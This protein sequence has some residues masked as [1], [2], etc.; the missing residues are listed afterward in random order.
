MEN[1]EASTPTSRIS[2]SGR[3]HST[4]RERILREVESGTSTTAA[5]VAATGL[6]ENTVRGHLERLHA[7]GF[8][9][10]TRIAP[11]GRGRP[12]WHWHAILP[13]EA[14]YAELA[15]TL[16]EAMIHPDDDPVTSARAA[17]V[18]WGERIVRDATADATVRATPAH[19]AASASLEPAHDAEPVP[20]TAAPGVRA[21]SA[22]PAASAD[23]EQAHDVESAP[24]SPESAPATEPPATPGH[25][26]PAGVA[27]SSAFASAWERVLT[28]MARQGFAPEVISAP[29]DGAA[30]AHLLQCP[31]FAAARGHER[32]VCTA[33]EGMIEGIARHFTPGARAALTPLVAPHTC[34][35]HLQENR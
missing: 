11:T 27:A 19:P 10:R 14:A 29:A 9:S 12:A 4:T 32:I 7:D 13:A 28:S 8:I 35:L 18:R 25:P 20:A 31:L 2:G 30:T 17:G 16:A 33:H 21:A 24:A 5:I 3:A 15:S 22:H 23:P 1:T 26:E 34:A 6:H